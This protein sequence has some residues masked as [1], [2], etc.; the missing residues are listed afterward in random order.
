MERVQKHQSHSLE[1]KKDNQLL[2]SM[3]MSELERFLNLSLDIFIVFDFD[4]KIITVNPSVERIFGYSTEEVIGKDGKDFIHTDDKDTAITTLESNINQS[5]QIYSSNRILCKDGSYKWVEWNSIPFVNENRVFAVGRDVT[6]KVLLQQKLKDSLGKTKQI[7]EGISETYYSIDEKWHF[8]YVN[9]NFVDKYF[10]HRFKS[11]NDVIGLSL[12]DVFPE[13][14]YPDVYAKVEEAIREQKAAKFI[15]KS[16]YRDKWYEMHLVPSKNGLTVFSQDITEHIQLTEQLRQSEESFIKAFHYSPTMVSLAEM[17]ERKF[18]DVNQKWI[19]LLGYT[20]KELKGRTPLELNLYVNPKE[21][22]EVTNKI[23]KNGHISNERVLLRSKKGKEIICLFSGVTIDV[24]GKKC[25]LANFVDIT[26]YYKLETELLRLERMNLIGQ[27][28]AG[29]GHEIRNPLQT[30]RGFLQLL[31]T[32]Y[33]TERE[34]F[35]LMIAELDRANYIITEFL[36]L[37][38]SKSNNLKSLLLDD[39][40]TNLFPLIQSKAFLEEKDIKLELNNS[41][42]IFGDEKELKQLIINLVR[43]GIEAMEPGKTL[44]IKTFIKNE[45][46]VL[47]VLDQGTGIDPEIFSK[48]G[49]PFVTSRADGTG[50]GLAVCYSIAERHNAKIEVD[51]S[52]EGTT[53]LVRFPHRELSVG[54][55]RDGK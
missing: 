5:R 49:T 50:L 24:K 51:T 1:G 54:N 10:N 38:K 8:E 18:M 6:D 21:Y 42:K 15:R 23:N 13:N 2:K 25:F 47:A 36:S 35:D 3:K 46:V 48:L 40:V 11:Q 20:P 4:W 17:P 32:K 31:E 33:Q 53:F 14:L 27:L 26:D 52:P 41:T 45:H 44:T 34:Y 55:A 29:L 37:S 39:I 7:L 30:V 16:T 12:L 43:N 22:E 19:E 9:Q 28:A